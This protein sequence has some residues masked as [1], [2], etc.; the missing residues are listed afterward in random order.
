M[1]RKQLG[2]L[3]EKLARDFLKKNGYHIRETNFKCPKGEIDIVAEKDDY[4]VF[5]EVRTK[6]SPEFGTP[7]ESITRLKKEKMVASAFTY[8]S[9][10]QDLPLQW[11]LDLVAIELDQESKAKRIELIQNVVS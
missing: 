11:R 10:H 5:V 7:E 2:N 6:S 9:T 3:G 4:L 8:L 1:K